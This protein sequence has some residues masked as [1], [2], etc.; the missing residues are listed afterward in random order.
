MER[1]RA[2]I[3]SLPKAE[4][5]LHIEGTLE[6]ELMF[7][8]ARENGVTIPFASVAEV[9]AA[10]NFANLQEFLDIYYAGARVLLKE[11]DFYALTMAYL[12]RAAAQNIRH[13]EIFFDPQTHT[14]RQV[15]F[16]DV[17]SGI[18]RAL[19]DGTGRL[20]ISSKLILCFLRHLSEEA[21]Q[22]TLTEALPYSDLIAGVG[23]DSSELGHPPEKFARVFARARDLGFKV[24]AH[25]GEEGPAEYVWQALQSLQVD[26]IDHGNR[27]ID[28]PALVDEILKRNLAL[29]LCPL[30]NLK[31]K[32]VRSLAEHPLKAML[33]RGLLVTINSDDPSYFGGY[34]NENYEALAEALD[35]SEEEV[36]GLAANSFRA[37][38]LSGTEK[39]AYVNSIQ[40]L[41]RV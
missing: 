8:L 10:Y 2:L 11:K 13:V 1:L 34:L 7:E 31:L 19:A 14:E 41:R 25:A 27:C 16:A 22:S 4:L 21:A 28:D 36:M 20:G 17:I 15:P 32:V 30:S 23:L 18:S 12:E 6:P 39:A 3:Q 40:A 35:L 5:H 38:F 26:R 33:S 29:T 9:R 37:S 24:M